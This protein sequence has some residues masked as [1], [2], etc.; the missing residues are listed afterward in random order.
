M[1]NFSF[2][3]LRIGVLSSLADLKERMD[4]DPAFIETSPYDN[5]ARRVLSSLFE[6]KVVEKEVVREVVREVKAGRGRPTKDVAL[7]EEDQE[8]VRRNIAD[9][10]AQL[11]DMG[12]GEDEKLETNE[13]IQIIKTKAN[14]NEQLLKMQERVFN[15][16]RMS[17]F[18]TIVLGVVEDL[19]PDADKHLFIERLEAYRE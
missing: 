18:Q 19:V 15:V 17:D 16:K 9:L 2:P 3:P 11:N 8:Q 12:T 6:P 5:E 13:R 7:S 14:L 10:L 4:E 1:S